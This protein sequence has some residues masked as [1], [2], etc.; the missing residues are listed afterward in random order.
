VPRYEFDANYVR[1]LVEGDGSIEEHFVRYFGEFLSLKLRS[2]LRSRETIEDVRQETFARV[3]K[4]LRQQRGIEHPERLGGFV[5][6]VCNNV[7]FEKFR[8]H[9]RYTTISPQSDAWPDSRIRMDEP[10]INEE[11]KLLV[12]RVLAKLRKRDVELLR[13][14]FLED[15]DKADACRRL[16]VTERNLRVVQHR[17]LIRFRKELLA[18]QT[19]SAQRL[20][21]RNLLELVKQQRYCVHY[22]MGHADGT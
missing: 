5:N 7:L 1:G 13:M 8:E 6:S 19:D 20:A 2:R 4:V 10:L 14:I 12:E 18:Q 16:G 21:R 15:V 9:N 22:R 11:R 17:A 3:F